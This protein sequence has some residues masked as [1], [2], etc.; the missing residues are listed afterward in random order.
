M[1]EFAD[2]DLATISASIEGEPEIG[3]VPVMPGETNGEKIKNAAIANNIAI[4]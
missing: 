2:T 3:S 1:K 4:A